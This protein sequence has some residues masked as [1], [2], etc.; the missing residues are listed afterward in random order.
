MAKRLL[1]AALLGASLIQP[2]PTAAP[3]KGPRPAPVAVDCQL[4]I[5]GRMQCAYNTKDECL[6][7][8]RKLRRTFRDVQGC[9]LSTADPDGWHYDL[10]VLEY[11]P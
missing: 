8:A 4:D 9:W 6:A 7:A 5:S 11:Y 10:Y 3:A 1:V 2:L